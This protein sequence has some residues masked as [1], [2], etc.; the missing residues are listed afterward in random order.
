MAENL[1]GGPP[2]IYLSRVKNQVSTCLPLR[3][4]AFSKVHHFFG[5]PCMLQKDKHK[6]AFIPILPLLYLSI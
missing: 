3:M 2:T 5:T 1:F 6:Y 4:T